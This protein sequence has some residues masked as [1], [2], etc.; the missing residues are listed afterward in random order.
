[1]L[2]SEFTHETVVEVLHGERVPDPYRW[3]ED[4]N[5]P[6]TQ[7][8]I[9]NQQ[10][11]HDDYFSRLTSLNAIRALVCEYLCAESI[12]QPAQVGNALFFRRRGVDQEQPCIWAHDIKT[13]VER[14]LVDPSAG[15]FYRSV[16]IHRISEDGRLL[17]YTLRRGGEK[18]VELHFVDVASGRLLD[19][20]LEAGYERGIAFSPDASGFYYCHDLIGTATQNR[21]HEIRYHR[22]GEN[23]GRD[24]LLFT[25]PRTQHSRLCLISDGV[26]LGAMLYRESDSGPGIDFYLA[27]IGGS[28]GWKQF[29]ANKPVSYAPFLYK[30]R[31]YALSFASHPF[32]QVVELGE[33]ANERRVI[34]PSWKV[35]ISRLRL[36]SRGFYVSYDVEGELKVHRFTPNGLFDGVLPEHPEGTLTLLPT[37]TANCD[38][39]FFS[40]ESFSQPPSIL[41]YHEPTNSYLRF[42][43]QAQQAESHCF[44]LSR[45]AYPSCDGV[46]VPMWLVSLSSQRASD[47]H[48]TLL[49]AYGGFGVSM[50]PR[51]SVL[52]A[53]MIRLGCV[54][55][56][57][58]IRGG[59][60]FG[61]EWHEAA[62]RRN[63]QIAFN[64]FLSAAEWLN[65]TGVTRPERLAI[66]GGSNSGLLVA[67]AMTQRPTLFGAVLC[68]APL[69]DMLRYEVFDDAVKW[70]EEY[71]T[72]SDREDF[73]ALHA[74]SPYHRIADDVNYPGTLF[75]TGDKDAQCNPAHVRKMAARLQGRTAQCNPILVDYTA[76]RGHSA[77]LPLSVRIEALTRRISFLCNELGIRDLVGGIA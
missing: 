19:D 59:S 60:E 72:V 31:V 38:S 57:P 32:G 55:A 25:A 28:A 69:L 17:A 8:W 63:R 13:E 71:G 20:H 10:R 52:V 77:C 3:L 46:S 14:V 41:E 50:K 45:V 6:S 27:P 68:I 75:V 2:S 30:G 53:I 44:H 24:D 47:H 51:F 26:H 12:D 16:A 74:Y 42:P 33:G 5:D 67:A 40:L 21:P 29:F 9:H 37:Y 62:R 66:F 36:T 35:G 11:V 43:V 4:R 58:N 23:T 61:P 64:D 54:F 18:S 48:P 34:I 70:R 15:G 76:E 1:M 65:R 56:L 39:L 49:S 73:H 22:F 7:A